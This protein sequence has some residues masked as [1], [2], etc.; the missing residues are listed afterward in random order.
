MHRHGQ[1]GS[2]DDA[3]AI[4]LYEKAIQ[5]GNAA[6]MTNRAFMHHQGEG[7]SPDY[8]KAIELYEKAI[9]LGNAVAM[10][11]RASMHR[12]GQGGS[13]DYAKAIELYEKA[14][15]AGNTEAID[16]LAHLREQLKKDVSEQIKRNLKSHQD[17]FEFLLK[18][19]KTIKES[20]EKKNG[21]SNGYTKVSNKINALYNSLETERKAF[22]SNPT[23]EQFQQFHKNC[24]KAMDEATKEAGQHRG[25]HAIHPIIKGIMGVLAA[26]AVLPAF[27]VAVQSKHGYIGTFFATPETTTSEQ[28]SPIKKQ[29]EDEIKSVEPE[30]NGIKNSK[31]Q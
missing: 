29:F 30:E 23:T 27:I 3:K 24:T 22:F 25:W 1:G 8:A 12:H 10:T 17:N 14:I 2:K 9:K 6:A 19:L 21:T 11:N 26:I 13:K 4:E 7:D 16:L 20:L 5:L 28:M 31:N 18:Q 15:K